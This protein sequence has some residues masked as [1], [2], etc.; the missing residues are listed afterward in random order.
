[1]EF[2]ESEKRIASVVVEFLY[3]H[4]AVKQQIPSIDIVLFFFLIISF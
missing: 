1:M 2:K 3:S 4:F